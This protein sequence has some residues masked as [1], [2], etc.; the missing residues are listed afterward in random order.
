MRLILFLLSILLFPTPQTSTKYSADVAPKEA[1]FTIPVQP[2]DRWTWRR[3]DTRDNQQEYRMD[4]T[5]KN[6]GKEY[7]FGVLSLEVS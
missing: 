6:D 3:A 7:T 1:T 4:V 5:V 2:R